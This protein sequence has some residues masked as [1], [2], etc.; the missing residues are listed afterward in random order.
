VFFGTGIRFAP[1]L[2]AAAFWVTRKAVAKP[3]A[4]AYPETMPET[5]T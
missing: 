3:A 4:L 2:Q 5:G 1:D